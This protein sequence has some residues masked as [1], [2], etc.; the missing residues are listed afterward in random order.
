MQALDPVLLFGPSIESPYT[1][2]MIEELRA[3]YKVRV[4]TVYE[5]CN[6]IHVNEYP[7]FLDEQLTYRFCCPICLRYMNHVLISD[8]CAN[9]LCRDCTENF[10]KRAIKEF[11][12]D[13]KHETRCP[14]CFETAFVLRDVLSTDKIKYYTDTPLKF[15]T[16]KAPLS[17]RGS[18]S[19]NNIDSFHPENLPEPDS[20][21]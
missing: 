1:S 4:N 18:E 21:N 10:L 19:S 6:I 5:K 15:M 11:D 2:E 8:C 20:S 9:Y 17:S 14:H 7:S 3:K 13:S 16:N 12:Q